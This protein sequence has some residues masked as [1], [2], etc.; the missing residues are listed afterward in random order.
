MRQLNPRWVAGVRRVVNDC[1]Y[2]QLQS[3]RLDGLE[4]GESE[5]SI[6]LDTKHLQPFGLVHGGVAASL[7]DAAA[8]WALYTQ[9][10]EGCGLTT[11]E[12][13]L[14]Y[15]SPLKSGRLLGRGKVIRLGRSLGLAESRLLDQEGNLAAHGTAT[16]MVL[17]SLSLWGESDLPPKHL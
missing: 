12:M 10:P 6:A 9:T 3:M 2:F 11:V 14:N 5:L 15:L 13:K 4:W 8:F 7:V 16:L 17:P 1:P